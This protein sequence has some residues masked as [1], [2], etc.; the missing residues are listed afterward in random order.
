MALR[1]DRQIEVDDISY[2]MDTTGEAGGI[3]TATTYASGV[4]LD[5]ASNVVAYHATGSGQVPVGVLMNDVVNKD[6]TKTHLNYYKNE[7]QV[8]DK[9][10]IGRDGW[11][12]TNKVLG[13]PTAGTVAYVGASG[14][15]SG[16]QT[17]IAWAA[18]GRFMTSKDSDGYAKVYV[19]LP[20]VSVV[21][22]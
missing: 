17:N 16:T 7:V 19:K 14:N 22:S 10:C 13:T 3:L 20:T 2:F 18:V 1:P 11:V 21:A 15:F 8:G 6:L 5:N 12:V 9:V 4:G